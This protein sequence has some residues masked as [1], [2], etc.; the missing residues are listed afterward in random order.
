MKKYKVTFKEG[1]EGK[2]DLTNEQIADIREALKAMTDVPLFA[3]S[4]AKAKYGNCL[5]GHIT[6][7]I[8]VL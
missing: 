2:F 3:T 1:G 6:S 5:I 4:F 8:E 7:I